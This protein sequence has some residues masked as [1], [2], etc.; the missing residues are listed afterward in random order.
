MG[1]RWIEV[2][3]I[4]D[5]V[6]RAA[7]RTE[8][9][10]LVFPEERISYPELAA[11]STTFAASLYGLGIR[12]GDKVG[13]LMHN[14]MDFAVALFA[15]SRLGAVVVP[16]NGRF[17]SHELGHV[18]SHADIRVLLTATG[19]A[20]ATDY[21]GLLGEVFPGLAAQD[22][23]ALELSQA[24]MLRHIVEMAS[25]ARTGGLDFPRRVRC[26]R[27]GRQPRAGVRTP[28]ASPRPRHRDAHVHV[29]D[30]GEAQGLPADPRVARPSRRQRRSQPLLPHRGGPLS[31]IRCRSSTSAGSCPC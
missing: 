31:G 27:I 2:A 22:A 14:C 16:V 15:A 7:D 10:A 13:I 8:R 23:R 21:P 6:E 18:L 12:A 24:P 5:L 25:E 1:A 11:R 29:G 3:T 20:G 28:G 9:D 17:K 26:G 19:P 4:G 30:D